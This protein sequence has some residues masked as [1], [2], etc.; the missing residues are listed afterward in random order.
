MEET[1][2]AVSCEFETNYETHFCVTNLALVRE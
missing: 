1:N 2:S